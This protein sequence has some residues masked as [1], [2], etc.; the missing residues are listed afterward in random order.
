LARSAAVGTSSDEIRNP[1]VYRAGFPSEPSGLVV[2]DFKRWVKETGRPEDFPRIS[3]TAPP[4]DKALKLLWEFRVN[5]GLRP[6]RTLVPCPICLPH[7]QKYAHGFLAWSPE[8]K[9]IYAIGI[10]CGRNHFGVRSFAQAE[11]ALRRRNKAREIEDTL[12]ARLPS[13]PV[14]LAWAEQSA[15]A[16]NESDR[17][18]REFRSQCKTLFLRLRS[19]QHSG[20]VLGIDVTGTADHHRKATG[21]QAI[22]QLRGGNWLIGDP[23]LGKRTSALHAQLSSLNMGEDPEEIFLAVADFGPTDLTRADRFLKA[24]IDSIGYLRPRLAAASLFLSHE[25]LMGIE[26]WA[27]HPQIN[28]RLRAQRAERTITIKTGL[29]GGYDWYSRIHH[30]DQPPPFPEISWLSPDS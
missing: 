24:C 19:A 16:A 22:H 27:N 26:R 6:G 1:L 12:L 15:S 4:K 28:L 3:T 13:I 20:G 18:A 8:A 2:S 11:E 21:L 17:L 9:A 14:L 5:T 25:N 10:E 7:G 30:I 29:S 23:D